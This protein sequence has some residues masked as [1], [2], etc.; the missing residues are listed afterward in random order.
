LRERAILER[1]ER[2][3]KK[4]DLIDQKVNALAREVHSHST[5][6]EVVITENRHMAENVTQLR[7]DMEK[8]G[9]FGKVI[10]RS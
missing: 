3:D 10:R 2:V 1:V 7:H 5:R 6:L 9:N 4:V 8:Y